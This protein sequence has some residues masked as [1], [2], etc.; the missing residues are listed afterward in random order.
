MTT[1]SKPCC[2]VAEDQALIALALEA[3][4]EEVG[5]GIAGPFGSCVEASA[6]VARHTP[7]LAL[8]DFKLR[9]GPCTILAQ[10]L[11]GRGVPVIITSGCPQGPDRPPELYDVI[12]LEKPVDPACLL[13]LIER[14]A[15]AL[16]HDL[17]SPVS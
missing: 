13:A 14:V 1:F 2:L 6:W 3:A 16:A 17:P 5:I 8:L 11:L 9:D 15:P 4:L 7:E 10:T 12:W